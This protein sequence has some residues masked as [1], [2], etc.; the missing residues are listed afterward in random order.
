MTIIFRP[1]IKPARA[2]QLTLVTEMAVVRTLQGKCGLDVGIKW[3]NDILIGDKK[4]C[5][6]LTAVNVIQDSLEYV[7]V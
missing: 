2:A 5:G 3:P 6:I 7:M 4:V 1:D